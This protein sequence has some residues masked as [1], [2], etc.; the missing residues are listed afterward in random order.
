M[1]EKEKKRICIL[2]LAL[3]M[4]VAVFK[5]IDIIHDNKINHPFGFFNRTISSAKYL[6]YNWR[7]QVDT[8]LMN[9]DQIATLYQTGKVASEEPPLKGPLFAVIRVKNDTGRGVIGTLYCEFSQNERYLLD[10]KADKNEG[11]VTSVIPILEPQKL[12]KS[13]D[14]MY[15]RWK[16]LYFD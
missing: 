2:V 9:S 7:L 5:V 16:Y 3:W 12:G 11:Y 13:S 15:T 8:Y 10:V 6:F 1:L 14:Y 4:G